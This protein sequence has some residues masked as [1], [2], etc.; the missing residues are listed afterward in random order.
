LLT[1]GVITRSARQGGEVLVWSAVHGA[2]SL[3]IEGLL[4]ESAFPL[5]INGVQR[6]LGMKVKV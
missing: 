5:I 6:S 2:S 3:A 1:T 4:P